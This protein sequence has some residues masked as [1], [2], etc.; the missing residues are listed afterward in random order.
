MQRDIDIMARTIYGEA[1]GESEQG[2]IAVG[3]VIMNRFKS[4]R[5]YAGET[6]AETC[7]KARQFSCWNADD[8]NCAKIKQLGL[9]R[10]APY[11]E[12]A[13]RI[14]NGVQ[15]DITDGATHYH[16]KAIMPLW[17]RNKKPCA[18]IGEHMFYKDID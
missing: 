14:I 5:W 13:K 4:K 11:Q 10:L 6:I 1:R 9:T 12:L 2:Q 18:V 7:L 17:A 3:C 16:T 15:A 8:P